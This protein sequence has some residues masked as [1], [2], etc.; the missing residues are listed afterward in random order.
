MSGYV[1]MYGARQVGPAPAEDLATTTCGPLDKYVAANDNRKSEQLSQSVLKSELHY[2]PSTGVFTRNVARGNRPAGC[3]VG[4]DDGQGYLKIQVLG[5]RHKAHRL[6]WLYMH[7]KF[8]DCE[9]DHINGVKS[10][11][12]IKN[13]RLASTLE[14]CRNR[15]VRSDNKI[16]LKGVSFHPATGK[17]RAKIS[18]GGKERSLGLHNTPEQAHAAYLF[19]ARNEFGEFAR[20]S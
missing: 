13:L 2:D 16:G 15:G 19:A 20:A 6:A 7:G 17:Y 14:N 10:D 4:T 1:N 11:N 3:V 18:F 12:R 8:P 5:H 9:I